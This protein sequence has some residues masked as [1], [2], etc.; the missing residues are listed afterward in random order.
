MKKL[1]GCFLCVM[2]VVCLAGPA[3]AVPYDTLIVSDQKA[4]YPYGP[5]VGEASITS[6]VTDVV[7]AYNSG[8]PGD[9]IYNVGTDPDFDSFNP[10]FAWTYAVVHTGGGGST[11]PGPDLFVYIDEPIPLGDD[12]LSRD[13][14]QDPDQLGVSWIRY[15][16]PHSVPEPATMLLLGSGLLG[17]ALFGRQRFKK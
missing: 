12:I 13:P 6:W 8:T 11:H 14:N 2:L 5:G 1:L 15:Y 3:S 16:G 17:L 7:L 9:I 4:T 10:G